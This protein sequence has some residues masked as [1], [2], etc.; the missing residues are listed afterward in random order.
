[1]GDKTRTQLEADLKFR[2]ANRTDIDTQLTLAVQY[3]Y[4]ELTTSIRIP[5]TQETAVFQTT[6][7]VSTVPVPTD[8][9]APV[10]IRNLTDGKRLQPMTARQYDA[11]QDTTTPGRPENYIW[12]RNEFI[13]QPTP[14][15]TAR[16][17]QLRYL[18]RL[19]AL[20]VAGSISALP[21][22]WDEVIV[23]G[24]LARLYS[25][26][27]LKQEAQSALLEFNVMVSKRIDRLS[28]FFFDPPTPSQVLT[29]GQT[30]PK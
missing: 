28:E 17:M 15:A 30:W 25:W 11:L 10:S 12:W 29:T 26:M 8:L 22:E 19:P 7:G 3:S 6:S 1:M 20:S 13:W 9:Y 4:D 18:K 21:R 27:G 24:G 5:E 14:D 2:M 16:I 23:Q